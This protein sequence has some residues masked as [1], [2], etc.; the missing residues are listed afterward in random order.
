VFNVADSFRRLDTINFEGTIRDYKKYLAQFE[1][2][3][4]EVNTITKTITDNWKGKG[5]N[6]FRKDCDQVQKNLQDINDIMN[7][8]LDELVKSH[9]E[10]LNADAESAKKL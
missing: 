1:G 7:E 9:E 8:M 3:V 10:Y 2:I 6:A 5:R 4:R